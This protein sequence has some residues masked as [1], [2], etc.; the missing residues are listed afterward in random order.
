MASSGRGKLSPLQSMVLEGFFD[1][2]SGFW[3]T[4]G[5]ALAGFHLRHRETDD[6]DLFTDDPSAFER[7]HAVIQDVAGSLGLEVETVQ[8][9][10]GFRRYAL[11]A[12]EQAVVVDLVLDRVRQLHPEKLEL[13]G[14][15]VDPADEILANTLTTLVGRTE[16]RDLVDVLFLER[17]GLQIEDSLG[18]AND[19]DGGCTPATLAWLLSEIT[20]PDGVALP[21]DVPPLELRAWLDEVVARLRR[22]AFPDRA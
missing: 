15:R 5:A 17:S 8:A 1:R 2:E 4:G 7:G 14:I 18:A 21:A 19:K 13:A 6:L 10:P 22:A 16:E 3:L 20:I 11:A 12:S 9:A